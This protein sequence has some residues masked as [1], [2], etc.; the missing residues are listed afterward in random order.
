M[1]QRYYGLREL[2]FDL[3]P[4]PRYLYLTA[5]HRE[6]LCNLQY[7]ISGRRGV[8]L[9]VGEAGTGKTTLVRAVLESAEQKNTRCI[10]LNNPALTRSEFVEFMARSFELSERAASSK[11]TMLFELE[12]V[13]YERHSTGSITALLVDEAQALPLELLE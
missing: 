4:N 11:T 3:T 8:T 5:S 12:R 9:L 13:L 2:P 10:Y 1:Y 7:G 6:A